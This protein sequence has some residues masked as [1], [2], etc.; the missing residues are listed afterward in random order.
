MSSLLTLCD[1]KQ[2]TIVVVELKS[3]TGYISIHFTSYFHLNN[4]PELDSDKFVV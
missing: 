4:T 2:Y 1:I 3:W